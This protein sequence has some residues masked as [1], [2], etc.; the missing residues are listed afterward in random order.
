MG[1][2]SF[3]LLLLVLL[4]TASVVFNTISL[5]IKKNKGWEV[6]KFMQRLHFI[7]AKFKIWSKDIFV[8]IEEE[9]DAIL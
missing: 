8:D 7:K 6:K 9:K 1:R 5:F 2:F 4:A 3:S